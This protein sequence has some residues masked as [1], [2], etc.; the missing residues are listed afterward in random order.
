MAVADDADLE[1]ATDR[2]L[3]GAFAVAGQSCISVQRIYVHEKVYTRFLRLFKAKVARLKVGNPLNPKT[4]IGTLVSA[5]AVQNTRRMIEEAVAG[6]AKVLLGGK[7]RRNLFQPTVLTHV[8]GS[9]DVCAREAFAPLVVVEKYRSFK[10]VV[11]QINRSEYGLQAGFFTNRTRDIF[12]AYKYIEAGG[13]VINDVPTY[14]ADH[15][16]YGGMKSSGLKRE[17]VRYSIEDMTEIKI[18]SLNL[19]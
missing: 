18:L 19:K 9:M 17:G 4:D 15:Q 2:I 7:A 6:G 5:E 16:P 8:K 12:Y 13:V 11:D 10:K 14:R 3:F 1:W